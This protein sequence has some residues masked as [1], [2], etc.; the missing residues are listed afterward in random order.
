MAVLSSVIVVGGGLAGLRTVEA[1]RRGGYD[2]ALTLVGAEAH[3][4]YDRPPLSKQVLT[5]EYGPEQVIF[6]SPE[7][8]EELGVEVLLGKPASSLS[9]DRRTLR[10][11]ER[12]LAFDAA[13]IASGAAARTIPNP[14]GLAGVCALRT[15]EDA[16]SVSAGLDG[17]PRVV[18]VGAGPI[19][20]EVASSAKARGA[21]VTVLE[22]LPTPFV[23]AVGAEM[24]AVCGEL[25]G[26]HGVQLMCGAR[27]EALEGAGRVERVRL[28]DGRALDADLVVVGIGVVPEIGWLAGS[29]LELGDG[30]V[31]DA[32]L[33]TSAPGIWAIGDV[34]SWDNELV[35]E[36]MRGE[37]WTNAT[38]QARHVARAML[39]AADPA[40]PYRSSNYFWS[41]QYGVRIQF[42]GSA[43]ADEVRVV[44]GSVPD[45][46][47]LALYR[48]GDRLVGAFAIDNARLLMKSKQIIEQGGPWAD[49]LAL[50]A[51]ETTKVE[52]A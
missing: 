14:E 4:P 47:L 50:V 38:D 42:A 29:G 17:R 5:G 8:F 26:D 35:G 10:V 3:L 28:S 6:R 48:R 12:E 13:V 9:A 41:D 18:V 31:C 37:Q 45:R 15:L 19:G 32:A 1:L 25:H 44:E 51:G 24:G 40:A 34:A 36:R 27:V 49:G 20:S 33:R 43:S 39:G 22:A 23:R 46:R 21:D 30:V 7:H 52:T 11:G 16:R 2:G